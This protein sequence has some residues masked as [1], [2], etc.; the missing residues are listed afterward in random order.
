MMTSFV[1]GRITSL[2]HLKFTQ[3]IFILLILFYSQNVIAGVGF[4]SAYTSICNLE[5][6]GSITSAD[7]DALK[8]IIAAYNCNGKSIHISLN[9]PGGD[10][11]AGIELGRFIRKLHGSTSVGPNSSCASS[12]VLVLVGGVFRIPMGAIGLH[13]PFSVQMNASSADAAASYQRNNE[14]ISTYLTQM[15]I[16]VRLLEE[17][18]AVS[19]DDVRWISDTEKI[20]LHIDGTDPLFDDVNASAFA[21]KHGISKQEYYR[22]SKLSDDICAELPDDGSLGTCYRSVM[23]TGR[24]PR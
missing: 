24:A 15:N 6:N 23:E 5:I 3:S 14:L 7:V 19:P 11:D 21:K 1:C 10:V 22:R 16:P 13:R 12:C 4:K 17:M 2:L 8:A 9:S 18:N 20:S